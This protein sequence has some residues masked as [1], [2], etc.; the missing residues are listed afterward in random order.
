VRFGKTPEAAAA[1]VAV[2]DEGNAR[3]IRMQ[4]DAPDRLVVETPRGWQLTPT[5]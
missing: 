2:V 4:C 5:A 3:L 1:W